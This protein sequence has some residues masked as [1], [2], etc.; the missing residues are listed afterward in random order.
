MQKPLAILSAIQK[1]HNASRQIKEALL[2]ANHS[3]LCST[4]AGHAIPN[5]DIAELETLTLPPL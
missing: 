2:Y 3:Q 1:Q 5:C 4:T